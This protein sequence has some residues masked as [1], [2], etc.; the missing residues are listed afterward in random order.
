[1]FYEEVVIFTLQ[2]VFTLINK[3][4]ISLNLDLTGFSIKTGKCG[5]EAKENQPNVKFCNLPFSLRPMSIV[6]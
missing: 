4:K 2:E 5:F 6:L 3:K 1:M